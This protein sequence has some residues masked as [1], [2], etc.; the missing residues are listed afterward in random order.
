MFNRLLGMSSREGL[1]GIAGAPTIEVIP[2]LMETFFGNLAVL[3]NWVYAS[4]SEVLGNR[5]RR[6]LYISPEYDIPQNAFSEKLTTV[7][8]KRCR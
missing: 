4:N 7:E 2:R 8:K 3:G 5:F 6:D 1:G